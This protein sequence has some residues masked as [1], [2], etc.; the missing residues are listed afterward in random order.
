MAFGWNKDGQLGL[1]P[2]DD[3]TLPR[4]LALTEP[5]VKVACGWSHTL[6][7]TRGGALLAWGSNGYGQLGLSEGRHQVFPIE[8]PP[9]VT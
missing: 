1:G 6:A 4:Q 7:I 5:I 8:L 9:T 3:V 2:S